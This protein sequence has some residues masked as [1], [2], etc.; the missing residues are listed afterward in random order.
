[1]RSDQNGNETPTAMN[2]EAIDV[3]VYDASDRLIYLKKHP[4]QQGTT[5]LTITVDRQP[6]TAGIDPLHKLID[7][8]PEDNVMPIRPDPTLPSG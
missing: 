1:M 2:H 7:T 6:Q 8:I 5:E 3:G 4:F